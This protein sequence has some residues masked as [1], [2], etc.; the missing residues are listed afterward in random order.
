MSEFIEL[1][2]FLIYPH[3]FLLFFDRPPS[4]VQRLLPFAG[5]LGSFVFCI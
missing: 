3:Q 5:K 2:D 1:G 4:D